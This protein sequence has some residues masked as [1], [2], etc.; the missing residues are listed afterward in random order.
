MSAGSPSA[1]RTS[2]AARSVIGAGTDA[3]AYTSS[4]AASALAAWTASRP[5]SPGPAPTKV[6]RPTILRARVIAEL[7]II[8][9]AP[10]AISSAA[11]R[12][13]TPSASVT[14][15]VADSRTASQPSSAVTDPRRNTSSC[16][17]VD[18]ASAIS[19][20]AP[21][22]AVQPASSAA[23]SARS[24]ATPRGCRDCRASDN[25]GRGRRRRTRG[26]RR[27]ARPA[28]ARAASGSGRG[29]R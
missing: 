2:P 21:T 20:S 15:P 23:S 24:A 10:S 4:A 25:S 1:V 7:P 3:S 16:S 22:G 28:R 12:R 8:L 13:P 14:G 17:A 6:I 11:S 19:A 18:H 27:P 9:S 5:G 26:T 29:S